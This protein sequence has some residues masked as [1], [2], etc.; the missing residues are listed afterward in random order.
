VDRGIEQ[1]VI[2]KRLVVTVAAAALVIGT[3]QTEAADRQVCL[4]A[5]HIDHTKVV[6]T[7]TVL[8]YMKDGKVWQNNLP[9]ACNGL[10]LHGFTAIGHEMEF[11]GGQGINILE[12]NQACSLGSF[13]APSGPT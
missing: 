8:F 3:V 11:C 13:T 4:R 6:N 2:M 10:A 12:V 7:S 1:E 9:T 5:D